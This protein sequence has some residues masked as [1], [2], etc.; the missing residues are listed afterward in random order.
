MGCLFEE[1]TKVTVG[2]IARDLVFLLLDGLLQPNMLFRM[3]T[4]LVAVAHDNKW[5]NDEPNITVSSRDSAGWLRQLYPAASSVNLVILGPRYP[6]V[7]IWLV[8]FTHD[9]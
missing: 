4:I 1:P 5:M 8:R 6:N 3:F 9:V 7:H 2:E